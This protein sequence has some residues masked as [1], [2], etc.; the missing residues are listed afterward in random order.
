MVLIGKNPEKEIKELEENCENLR[1]ELLLAKRHID[2]AIE[3]LPLK[4][5]CFLWVASN[6]SIL[7]AES[8][9]IAGILSSMILF[10]KQEKEYIKEKAE[11]PAFTT[12]LL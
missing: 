6:H 1:K 12:M 8:F 4:A 2:K 11:R 7:Q 3:F 9:A 5:E 10:L